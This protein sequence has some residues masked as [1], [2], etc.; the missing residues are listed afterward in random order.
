MRNANWLGRREYPF[1]PHYLELPIGRLHDIDGGEGE[2]K[3]I[4]LVHS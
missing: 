2:G 4:D 3:P 1:R